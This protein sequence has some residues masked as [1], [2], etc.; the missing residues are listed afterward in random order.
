MCT[1]KSLCIK[2]FRMAG[3]G[4]RSRMKMGN[5]KENFKTKYILLFLT[6][7]YFEYSFPFSCKNS[8]FKTTSTW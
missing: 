8:Y 2:Y 6:I 3:Y 7:V 4:K 1:N 5:S